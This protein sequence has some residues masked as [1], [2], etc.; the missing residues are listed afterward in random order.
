MEKMYI[1]M[2]NCM[3]FCYSGHCV[4][5]LD[6]LIEETKNFINDDEDRCIEEI[7]DFI[8]D[9]VYEATLNDEIYTGISEKS[10]N[11]VITIILYEC[12]KKEMIILDYNK[13]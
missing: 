3:N 4:F 13:K 7:A 6:A 9:G 12:Y 2:N 5:D 10:W 11:I 8:K 1:D